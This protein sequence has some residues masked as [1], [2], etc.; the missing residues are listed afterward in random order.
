MNLRG[1]DRSVAAVRFQSL[2][3]G[4]SRAKVKNYDFWQINKLIILLSE[5]RQ[6]GLPRFT[7]K[8]LKAHSI[9]SKHD[10]IENTTI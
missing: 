9:V 10:I 4:Y 8:P 5:T 6:T 7:K 2:Q 3:T 1:T